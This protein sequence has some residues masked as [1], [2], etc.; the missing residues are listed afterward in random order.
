L[1]GVRAIRRLIDAN[2]TPLSFFFMADFNG[3]GG[4]GFLR[5][6]FNGP[7]EQQHRSTRNSS[8]DK[9]LTLRFAWCF[10]YWF[11]GW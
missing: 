10:L 9:R 1:E 11:G 2:S 5:A 4:V 6:D 8:K 7:K 3:L